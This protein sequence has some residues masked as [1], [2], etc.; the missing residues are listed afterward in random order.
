MALLALKKKE[1]RLLWELLIRG[2]AATDRA[3]SRTPATDRNDYLKLR[4]KVLGAW[5]SGM[6]VGGVRPKRRIYD[7]L[8]D[9]LLREANMPLLKKANK[10]ARVKAKRVIS[11]PTHTGRGRRKTN[12]PVLAARESV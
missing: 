2:M 9:S 12:R 10:R 1:S 5:K 7:M 3:A 11:V 4:G 8:P 6:I